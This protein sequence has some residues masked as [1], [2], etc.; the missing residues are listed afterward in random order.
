MREFEAVKYGARP[1]IIYGASTFGEYTLVILRHLGIEPVCFCDQGRKGEIVQGVKVY[2]YQH[3]LSIK[4]AVVL[5]AVGTALKEVTEFLQEKGITEI[6]SIYQF[7]FGE[8]GLDVNQISAARQDLYYFKHL[9]QFALEHLE[10]E[11]GLFTLDWVITE[12]CSLRCRDCSNLMQYYGLPQ[13]Y[14]AAD[15]Q[16]NLDTILRITGKIFDLRVLGG[17]PFMNPEMAEIIR[18]YLA[19]PRVVNITIYTNATILPNEEIIQVLKHPKVKCQISNYGSLV[20]NFD[21]FVKVMQEKEIRYT[22][23]ETGLWQDLGKLENRGK[24]EQEMR[25]TF[26]GCE[27]NNLLTLLGDKIYRCPFSA[28]GRNLEAIPDMEEDRVSLCGSDEYILKKLKYLLKEK[29][30]DYA[31]GYCNGRSGSSIEP[32]VQS[33]EPMPYRKCVMYDQ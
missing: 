18:K 16:K 13:N 3:I 19:D 1:I 29:S 23:T 31:C 9:Y 10:K 11:E 25:Y 27:C 6:F 21:N 2:D 14:A 30:F 22:V 8:N 12:K 17:E 32:A 28:H 20:K 7:V 5:L 26:F 24:T 15:L 4:D 33:A